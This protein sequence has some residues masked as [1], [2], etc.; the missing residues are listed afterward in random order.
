[1]RILATTSL[2]AI[3]M[4]F[5][6]CSRARI[7]TEIKGGDTWT[8]TVALSGPE[9][10][11]GGMNMA[12]SVEETF[13]LP[14]TDAWKFH[15][16]KKDTERTLV[17][18]KTMA[19]GASLK[20]DLSIKGA[21]PAKVNLINEVTVSRVAPRRFEYRETLRWTGPK[22]DSLTFKPED[23]AQLK[24]ALPK[25]LATDAN[26]RAVMEKTSILAIPLLFGPGEPLLTLGLMHPDLAAHRMSQRVGAVIVK[27]LEEQFGDKMTLA[28]RREVTRKLIEMTFAKNKPAQPDPAAAAAPGKDSKDSGL[29]PLMFIV[30]SPGKVISTNGE[31]DE[32]T[33]EVYWGLFPEA[34]SYQPVILTL[35]LQL[36]PP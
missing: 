7:T 21:D 4:L 19:A 14:S 12:P 35:I 8:R 13:V 34:A 32:V 27:A 31:V 28:E 15:E 33:G 30:K 2:L 17:F 16:E 22:P 9:K 10:K 18:E 24:A 6:A 1:M 11:E 3:V 23:L 20:G 26:A 25:P 36:D 5:S 29:I